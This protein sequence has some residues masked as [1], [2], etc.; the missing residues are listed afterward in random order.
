MAVFTV[1]GIGGQ[2]ALYLS[3]PC[4]IQTSEALLPSLQPLLVLVRS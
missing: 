3:P 2:C 1:A 4:S